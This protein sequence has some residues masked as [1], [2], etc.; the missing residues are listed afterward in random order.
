[1][2]TYLHK[3]SES[4]RTNLAAEPS[5]GIAYP[6]SD[7]ELQDMRPRAQAERALVEGIYQSTRVQQTMQRQALINDRM[8]QET[9]PIQRKAEASGSTGLPDPLK[10]GVERLS[11]YA[12]DDVRVHYNSPKPVQY[13]AHAFAQGT[14]IHLSRGQEKHLP[15]EAWHV[16]QQKQG[17]VK[18]TLQFKGK[19]GLNDDPKLEREADLMGAK[20]LR[21][22]QS[23][24]D[25]NQNLSKSRSKAP[26]RQ[27]KTGVIQRK[28]MVESRYKNYYFTDR[29]GQNRTSVRTGKQM[30]AWLDPN[31]KIPGTTTSQGN[32][33]QGD[34]MKKLKN[35]WG[36]DDVTDTSQSYKDFGLHNGWM[37][38]GHLLNDHLGGHSVDANLFP[39]TDQA[40]HEHN[41]YAEQYVKKYVERD[42]MGVF[43]QIDVEAAYDE[44][45]PDAS[46]KWTIKRWTPGNSKGNIG[47]ELSESGFQVTSTPSR[48]KANLQVF[49]NNK[50]KHKSK[51]APTKHFKSSSDAGY[52]AGPTG[53]SVFGVSGNYSKRGSYTQESEYQEPQNLNVTNYNNLSLYNLKQQI[54]NN[55]S[56]LLK[57]SNQKLYEF[58]FDNQV[59]AATYMNS[60]PYGRFF[61]FYNWLNDYNKA[62][63]ANE[64]T[65][66]GLWSYYLWLLEA[67]KKVFLR[68]LDA[69]RLL[70]FYKY[71][72]DINRTSLLKVMENS[73]LVTLYGKL[74][75]DEN[76]A[77][78]DL[79]TDN[80]RLYSF[81][82]GFLLKTSL[83]ERFSNDKLVS[84]FTFLISNNKKTFLDFASNDVV[85]K[86]LDELNDSNVI[87]NHFNS[88]RFGQHY[89]NLD[90]NEKGTFIDNRSRSQRVTLVLGLTGN[91]QNNFVNRLSNDQL[92]NLLRDLNDT[93]RRWIIGWIGSNK[94]MTFFNYLGNNNKIWFVASMSD[95]SLV[96]FY[97]GLNGNNQAILR[98]YVEIN[99]YQRLTS[100]NQNNSNNSQNTTTTNN[101]GT[102][103]DIVMGNSN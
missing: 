15:H 22:G 21:K 53:M 92:Y 33:S 49:K 9:P 54:P 26:V 80:D 43:Y 70:R 39:I 98:N 13:Q 12:M 28:T 60:I 99:R 38:K 2:N 14:D 95:D 63:I 93:N 74:S 81:Y 86:L 32:D 94:M 25:G 87:F 96:S 51:Q 42:K 55:K 48:V 23:G 90:N 66:F 58:L 85:D 52:V 100:N 62:A 7:T 56:I 103:Q 82:N 101:Q 31:D 40:N 18:P 27:E 77:M 24:K 75:N 91:D 34:L 102:T 50:G 36:T 45:Q 61:T 69:D 5:A 41:Y 76:T 20:A 37:V 97:N 6:S 57:L 4:E 72:V 59:N 68:H 88:N 16:V 79:I 84:F 1:M 67:N 8:A 11:G 65:D 44:M 64:M 10:S 78:L 73:T 35:L 30:K 29:Q 71:L 89:L 47:D 83:I 17:R 3:S 19:V 46:Y